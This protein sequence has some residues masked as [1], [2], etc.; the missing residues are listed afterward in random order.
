[1]TK[2]KLVATIWVVLLFLLLCDL[3]AE[4][5]LYVTKKGHPMAHT[6][7]DLKLF[8]NSIVNNQTAIFLKLRQEGRA[9]LSEEG[10]EVYVVETVDD[11]IIKIR[12]TNSTTP[13]WTVREAV[14]RK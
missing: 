13:I 12:P 4:N 5:T 9:W 8:N 3:S 11:N 10:V 7:E 14:R 6:L 1:M 2:K